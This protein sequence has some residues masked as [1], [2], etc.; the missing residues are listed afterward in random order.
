ML[1]ATAISVTPVLKFAVVDR[2]ILNPVSSELL[3]VQV[4]PI[5]E[6][7]PSD[8]ATRL[9]GAAGLTVATPVTAPALKEIIVELDRILEPAA[10]E[11]VERARNLT[12]LSLPS[13][14]DNGRATAQVWADV[15]AVKAAPK[16]L[17][18]FIEAA[19]K[20]DVAAVQ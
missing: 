17:Q 10:P 15:V 3:S 6:V 11:E 16:R 7:E 14:F 4:R 18:A 5:R 20:V 19:P 12:A 8:V 1:A 13:R 9:L 2:R